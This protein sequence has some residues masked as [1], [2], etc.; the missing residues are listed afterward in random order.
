MMQLALY[1][2]RPTREGVTHRDDLIRAMVDGEFVHC[3]LR[4]SDGKVG[5]ATD[6]NGAGV[7]I[8][9]REFGAAGWL[10][11]DIPGFD[12]ATA[13]AWFEAEHAYDFDATG[14]QNPKNRSPALPPD[15]S[16]C[17][18]ACALAL[19]LAGATDANDLHRQ[20]T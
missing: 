9:D 18:T 16:Y 4:F 20:V 10:L 3:G 12:E 5:E 6:V 13:R 14:R 15:P 11:V 7:G 1:R 17:A 2:G 19:G 8:V